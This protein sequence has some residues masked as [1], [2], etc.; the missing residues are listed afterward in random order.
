[1]YFFFYKKLICLPYAYLMSERTRK[2]LDLDL[3]NSIV[4]FDEAHNLPSHLHSAN[5]IKVTMRE[6]N[7]VIIYNLKEFFTG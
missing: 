2:S 7:E 5:S 6:F 4:L 1:M 3:N